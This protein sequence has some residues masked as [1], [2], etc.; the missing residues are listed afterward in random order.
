MAWFQAWK[1]CPLW[2][3]EWR[4]GNDYSA[5]AKEKKNQ[6]ATGGYT[7]VYFQ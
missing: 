1:Y 2:L 4:E 3:I 6:L 5:N 7:N